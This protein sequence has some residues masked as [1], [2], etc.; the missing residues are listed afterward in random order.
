MLA[1]AVQVKDT[2]VLPEVPDT[3]VGCPG[4]VRGVTAADTSDTALVPAALVALTRNVY[5]VPFVK[6]VTVALA[7]VDVPSSN[8]A[9]DTPLLNSTT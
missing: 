4:V 1:G 5:G 9:H 3:L 8:D 7:A 6:P 2:W